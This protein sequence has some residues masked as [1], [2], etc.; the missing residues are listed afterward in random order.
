MRKS[1]YTGSDRYGWNRVGVWKDYISSQKG[2]EHYLRRSYISK[3]IN[4]NIKGI[5]LKLGLDNLSGSFVALKRAWKSQSSFCFEDIA[6]KRISNAKIAESIED[7]F[8]VFGSNICPEN[9]SS[10]HLDCEWKGS[11]P[12]VTHFRLVLSFYSTLE[13]SEFYFIFY[14]FFIYCW[15]QQDIDLYAVKSNYV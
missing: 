12:T 11:V 1:R 2:K 8:L 10:V 6:R 5:L 3:I 14:L 7:I 15:L 13:I 9:M 4:L